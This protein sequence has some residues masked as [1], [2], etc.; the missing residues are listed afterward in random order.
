MSDVLCYRRLRLVALA[1]IIEIRYFALVALASIIE[2][3]YFALVALASVIDSRCL[4]LVGET[5]PGLA[6]LHI[7]AIGRRFGFGLAV[8]LLVELSY[9]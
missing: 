8:L 7:G 2:I 3:R 9:R 5:V 4:Q 6:C 1:S